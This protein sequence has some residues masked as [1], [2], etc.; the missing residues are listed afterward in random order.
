MRDAKGQKMSKSKGNVIDPLDSINAYV[1]DA[2]RFS[3][4]A[5]AGPGRNVNFSIPQV[6]GYR[7]FTTKLFNAFRYCEQ[8]GCQWQPDFDVSSCQ[9]SVNRWVVGEVHQLSQ[10]LANALKIYRFDEAC[11]VLYHSI[12]GKFCDWYLEF[13]KPILTGD[14]QEAIAETKA[15]TAWV[16]GQLLHFLHP[17]MPFVTEE[18]WHQLSGQERGQLMTNPWPK[19]KQTSDMATNFAAVAEEMTWVIEFISEIRTIRNEMNVPV[20]AKPVLY[21]LEGEGA[22]H[23]WLKSHQET[24]KRMARL[25]SIEQGDV[26]GQAAGVQLVLPRATVF[27]V[28]EGIVDFAQEKDRLQKEIKDIE[29]EL[30]ALNR[31]LGDEKFRARAPREVV[32]KNEQRQQEAEIRHKK[33]HAAL[34]RLQEIA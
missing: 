21:L 6:E 25:S 13:T 16:F 23:G 30:S 27:M 24:I 3:L 20:A 18:L 22:V 17:F 10:E 2:V 11:G 31:K 1:A 14:D 28:L 4:A 5:L 7:N 32:A 34:K 9:L 12:W 33:I 19:L 15:T 26:E 29:G 8:N